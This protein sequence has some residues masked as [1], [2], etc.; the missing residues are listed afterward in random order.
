MCVC[1]RVQERAHMC[2]RERVQERAHVSV[3]EAE[4]VSWEISQVTK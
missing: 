2:E 1:E 4:P 3:L